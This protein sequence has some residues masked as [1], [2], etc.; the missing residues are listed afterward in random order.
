MNMHIFNSQLPTHYLSHK[1]SR[2]SMLLGSVAVGAT[3][4]C[5]C[6]G[7]GGTEDSFAPF[8]VN[9]FGAV[10]GSIAVKVNFFPDTASNGQ[11]SGNF[12]PTQSIIKFGP[13]SDLSNITFSANFKGSFNRRAMTLT[14]LPDAM[15]PRPQLLAAA[16]SGVFT[17]NDTIVLTPDPPSLDPNLDPKPITVVRNG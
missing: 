17:N 6:G 11:P 13:S 10:I 5:A 15:N 16:Y 8:F 1:L 7:G 14:L 12:D 2:R 3:S 9:I 4:Q